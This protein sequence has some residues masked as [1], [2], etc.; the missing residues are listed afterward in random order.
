MEKPAQPRR[1]RSIG[2]EDR[3]EPR[4]S[5]VIP[6]LNEAANLPGVFARMPE[7]HEIV[8]VDGHS[9]DDTVVVART[10]YPKIR[11]VQQNRRGKGNALACGF[12][13]ATGDILVMLDAD[14]SADPQ[15]IPRFVSALVAGADYAKGT[16]FTSDGGSTDITTLR[17]LGNKALNRLVNGLF[18][19]HYTDLCYGYNAFWRHCLD[20]LDLPVTVPGAG[21]KD[22]VYGDGFEIETLINVRIAMA[23]LS[24]TEV[25]SF[26]GQRVHGTSNLNAF[27][28]GLRVL[29]IIATERRRRTTSARVGSTDPQS[30]RVI[31]LDEPVEIKSA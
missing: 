8:L 15:E 26:E 14:G 29:R 1:R 2:S 31:N 12:A 7:V 5:V 19:T 13:V 16:R 9:C 25:G 11:I 27:S 17:R 6:T 28:D 10:L 23:G 30:N 18:G 22:M 20:E 21:P 4:V 3:A 24:V